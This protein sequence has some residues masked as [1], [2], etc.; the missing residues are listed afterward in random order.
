VRIT[1]IDR[2]AGA[3]S[4]IG[5][6]SHFFTLVPGDTVSQELGKG[7]HFPGQERG[8]AI[9]AAIV[10]NPHEHGEPARP[11][12]QGRYLRL[13]TFSDDQITFP[14]TCGVPKVGLRA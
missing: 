5:V 7:F 8:D 10:G 4:E 14:E 6:A 9:G 1:K 12:D 11:L 13:S 2:Q 3:D